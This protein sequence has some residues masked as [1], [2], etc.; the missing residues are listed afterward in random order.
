M[1]RKFRFNQKIMNCLGA[2]AL[3]FVVLAMIISTW[4]VKRSVAAE[5]RVAA[6]RDRCG[7][8]CEELKEA[9]DYL[10]EQA[11]LYAVT[12]D[13]SCLERYWEEVH[14]GKRR[15]GVVKRLGEL[16]LDDRD[17]R[18]VESAKK[19][20]DLLIYL[21]TR[22]MRLAADG[23]GENEEVLP[24]EVQ[25]YVL[26]VVEAAM[27]PEEKRMEAISLLCGDRYAGEKKVIDQYASEFMESAV[28]RM[29]EELAATRRRTDRALV[30]LWGLQG[31]SMLLF[32]LYAFFCYRGT[33]YPALAYQMCLE[34]GRAAEL[35]PDGISEIYRLG[36]SVLN[37]YCR[38]AEAMKAKDEF[39]ASVSHEIRTP[40]NSVIGCETLLKQTRLNEK[41]REYLACME[42]ASKQLLDMVNEL[43]DY[44][45]LEKKMEIQETE[46]SLREAA[47]DLENSFC[48]LAVEKGLEFS[49]EADD[50]VPEQVLADEGKFRL[51]AGNLISNAIKFTDEGLVHAELLWEKGTEDEGVLVLRVEDTGRGIKKEDEERIFEAFERGSKEESAP[52]AGTGLGLAICQRT[53]GLLRGSLT[54]E[55]CWRKGSAFTARIPMKI[56]GPKKG[57]FCRALVLLVDDNRINRRIQKELFAVLGVAVMEAES[58]E[59][60]VRM[61]SERHFD[62]IFMDLRMPGMSGYEAAGRIRSLK[63]F[64]CPI[65]A[66]TADGKAQIRERALAYGMEEVVMK[67]IS[68]AEL[69]KVLKTYISPSCLDVELGIGRLGGN[70]LLYRQVTEMFAEEHGR[71]GKKLM[72]LA[73]KGDSEE[74]YA[75]LHALK[76]ASGAIGAE[77]LSKACER[78]E[79]EL[80]GEE[81]VKGELKERVCRIEKLVKDLIGDMN[82][83]LNEEPIGKMPVEVSESACMKFEENQKNM[84]E[85]SL[86]EVIRFSGELQKDLIKE[87]YGMVERA[88]FAAEELW[89]D[90]REVFISAFGRGC[91]EQLERALLRF[92][93]EMILQRIKV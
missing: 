87:W 85:I 80:K 6:K 8:L 14:S 1:K 90:N 86:N 75:L 56:G 31:A 22:A 57:D 70:E 81:L 51:I 43:L 12:G 62:L 11:R 76:G 72:D 32:L 60:A 49:V 77:P 68:L 52:V 47:K 67:P 73:E 92:D 58:G 82:K 15:D 55:S 9:A 4:N 38:M 42:T 2:A 89:S 74:I 27:T 23:K 19:N 24:L 88:D 37:M 46:W 3:I 17:M 7:K 50:K 64:Q 10:S 16:G 39:L 18:L 25:T 36:Q 5:V 40:L 21:E 59:E 83:K 33:I 84:E 78:L 13:N 30:M 65:I 66:L 61:A 26:N 79:D 44:A 20:S 48:C 63:T 53:A 34:E 41:Q 71:D 28:K 91:A 69:E 54:V 93:Y 45:S 29:N 35:K